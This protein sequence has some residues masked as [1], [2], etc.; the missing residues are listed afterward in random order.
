MLKRATFL[1]E[2]KKESDKVEKALNVKA[3]RV[4]WGHNLRDS[5]ASIFTPV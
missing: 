2:K 4:T 1:R 3:G 5:G